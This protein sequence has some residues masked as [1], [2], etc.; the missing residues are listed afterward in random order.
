MEGEGQM[1]YP[2]TEHLLVSTP[3][4]RCWEYK[5]NDIILTIKELPIKF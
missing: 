4:T 5:Y 1:P 2:L 3:W